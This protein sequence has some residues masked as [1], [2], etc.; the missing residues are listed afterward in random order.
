MGKVFLREQPEIEGLARPH[1]E[2]EPVEAQPEGRR[3]DLLH[4]RHGR[5]QVVGEARLRVKLE[6][7]PHARISRPPGRVGETHR[8]PAKI[9]RP[10]RPEGVARDHEHRDAEIPT[11]REPRLEM[12]PVFP[13]GVAL[14]GQQAALETR[15]H[16]RDAVAGQPVLQ[17][18]DIV[19]LQKRVGVAQ[20]EVDR[21]DVASSIILEHRAERRLEAA[22]GG[23]RRLHGRHARRSRSMSTTS[24][25]GTRVCTSVSRSRSVTVLSVSVWPSIVRHQGVPASSCRA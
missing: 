18:G 9:L 10:E 2:L 15:R 11:E 25:T 12:R 23:D 4:H 3:A 21:V 24:P 5:L 6:R 19:L 1:A 22:D 16:R 17:G 14:A 8:Q 20:P 7:Q 13:A